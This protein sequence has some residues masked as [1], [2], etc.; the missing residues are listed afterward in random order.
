MFHLSSLRDSRA[1]LNN[2]VSSGKSLPFKLQHAIVS[3]IEYLAHTILW[4]AINYWASYLPRIPWSMQ[5]SRL[6]SRQTS[7]SASSSSPLTLAD[8]PPSPWSA[9]ASSL[10]SVRRHA[11]AVD[12]DRDA[13]KINRSADPIWK[14]R[15][16]V[17][18]ERR[19]IARHD[20]EER[21]VYAAHRSPCRTKKESIGGIRDEAR[22]ARDVLQK[23]VTTIREI[24]EYCKKRAGES[25]AHMENVQKYIYSIIL[26]YNFT[27]FKPSNQRM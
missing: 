12:R 21:L 8:R 3:R 26:L 25:K 19:Q 17:P 13:S 22:S 24:K 7:S 2:A 18:Y 1:L 27:L 11:R 16:N 9:D 20:S 14:A 23:N 15:S 5:R 4:R 6:F 10:P